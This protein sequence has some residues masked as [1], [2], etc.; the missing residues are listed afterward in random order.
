MWE[1][2]EDVDLRLD[3]EAATERLTTKQ[4]EAVALMLEGYTQEEIGARLGAGQRA[5]C[6][7][8]EAAVVTFRGNLLKSPLFHL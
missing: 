3:L 6:Y 2:I 4:R 7:R 8:I 5:I 1:A